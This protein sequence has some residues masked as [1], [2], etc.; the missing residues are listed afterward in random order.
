MTCGGDFDGLVAST[1][2]AKPGPSR[3][4][5]GRDLYATRPLPCAARTCCSRAIGPRPHI[6]EPSTFTQTSHAP[7]QKQWNVTVTIAATAA[8]VQRLARQ[9]ITPQTVRKPPD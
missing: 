4:I 5:D 6:R 8:Q 2:C 1:S 9:Q 3:R 7:M